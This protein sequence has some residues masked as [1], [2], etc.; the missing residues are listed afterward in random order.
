MRDLHLE[1]LLESFHRRFRVSLEHSEVDTIL[2]PFKSRLDQ[3]A[4]HKAVGAYIATG[5]AIGC[6]SAKTD[7]RH[8]SDDEPDMG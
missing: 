7:D 8:E 4:H 3:K 6:S 1:R 5:M 2:Q